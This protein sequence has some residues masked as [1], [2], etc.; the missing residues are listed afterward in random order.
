MDYG[1]KVNLMEWMPPARVFLRGLKVDAAS[2]GLGEGLPA[3][4]GH[5]AAG[6][7]HAQ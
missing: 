7:K 1:F 5:E 3:E 2:L 6:P 4:E